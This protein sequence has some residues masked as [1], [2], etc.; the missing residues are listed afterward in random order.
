MIKNIRKSLCRQLF[1]DFSTNCHY[2]TLNVSAD[3]SF[4]DIK[5]NYRALAK[6]LHP[7]TA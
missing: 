7:D 1:F 3:A 6:K 5:E 4:E 2:R